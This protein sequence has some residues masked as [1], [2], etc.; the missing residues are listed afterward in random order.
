MTRREIMT[1]VRSQVL[2]VKRLEEQMKELGI[3]GVR[4][5][6]YGGAGGGGGD[7]RARGLDVRLE[8]KEALER[9]IAREKM[10]LE[11]YEAA[12]RREMALMKPGEYAFCLMYYIGACTI[13]ETSRL[14]NRSVRQC[15][16]YRSIICEE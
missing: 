9:M 15:E 6:N 16:R 8:K 2:L 3:D 13:R 14:I 1:R 10:R 11:E 5:M 4:S 7:A 12:A